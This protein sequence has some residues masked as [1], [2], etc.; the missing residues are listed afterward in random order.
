MEP[1]GHERFREAALRYHSIEE[2]SAANWNFAGYRCAE[3][4]AEL[5]SDQLLQ[6]REVFGARLQRS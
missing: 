6:E 4:R 2:G 5:L 1:F 3:N